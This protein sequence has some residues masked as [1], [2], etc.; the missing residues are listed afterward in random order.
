MALKNNQI[1]AGALH[2]EYVP[3]PT[4]PTTDVT[5]AELL[6]QIWHINHDVACLMPKILVTMQMAASTTPILLIF[7]FLQPLVAVHLSTRG[8]GNLQ[9][10]RATKTRQPAALVT[11][12]QLKEP[13]Q[14]MRNF[15]MTTL[16]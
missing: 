3:F 10:K 13:L 14:V 7:F 15:K 4:A 11:C 16:S 8:V 5:T 1:K 9:G 2:T 6:E 12:S